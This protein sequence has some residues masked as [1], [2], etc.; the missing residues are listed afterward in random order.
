[1]GKKSFQRVG[2]V[3]THERRNAGIEVKKWFL[4]GIEKAESVMFVWTFTSPKWLPF[5]LP[6]REY[7]DEQYT[8]RRVSE[9]LQKGGGIDEKA[10]SEQRPG[11][12]DT[13][14]HIAELKK[15]QGG[16]FLFNQLIKQGWK[17]ADAHWEY[18]LTEE[19]KRKGRG[20]PKKYRVKLELSKTA[21]T[22]RELRE[23][24]EITLKGLKRLLFQT[25]GFAHV[26]DNRKSNQNFVFSFGLLMKHQMPRVVIA[27]DN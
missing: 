8:I 12:L 15:C 2:G 13:G 11:I 10:I 25:W 22:N 4:R 18:R 24:D 19:Q 7:G 6:K 23:L 21:K 5:G 1:M 17:I 26:W 14:R 27:S 16:I 9:I 20:E 3:P